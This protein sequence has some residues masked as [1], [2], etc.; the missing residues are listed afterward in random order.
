M[1]KKLPLSR[2]ELQFLK[3][4]D[5]PLS[6]VFDATGMPKPIYRQLMRTADLPFA[7]GTTPCRLAGHR[8]RT[9]SGHCIQ[10][11][12][13]KIAYMLRWQ[14]SGFIYVAY[15]DAFRLTKVG[16]SEDPS[17]RMIQLNR[18]GYGGAYD[19]DLMQIFYCS[20]DGGRIESKVHKSLTD[21][22]ESD[23]FY[24]TEY[25]N[26]QCYEIYSCSWQEAVKTCASVLDPV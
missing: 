24:D 13:A 19:W 1:T 25:V 20:R 6:K 14:K 23:A 9:R 16:F 17:A 11:D 5:I 3:L 26:T 2:E 10:C 21:W 12:T 4:H 22:H 8:L 7:C 15:S 18:V